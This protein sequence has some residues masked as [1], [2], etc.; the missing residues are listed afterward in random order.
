MNKIPLSEQ[1]QN[2]LRELGLECISIRI[3]EGLSIKDY[4]KHMLEKNSLNR[5]LAKADRE[6]ISLVRKR[7]LDKGVI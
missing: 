3:Q 6:I 4:M 1:E 7:L 2:T 5:Q